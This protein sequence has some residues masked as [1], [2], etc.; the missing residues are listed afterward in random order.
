MFSGEA[1]N[2]NLKVLG[3]KVMI[4]VNYILLLSTVLGTSGTFS[5]FCVEFIIVILC[6]KWPIIGC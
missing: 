5:T 1:V 2:T 6:V 4:E 3:N